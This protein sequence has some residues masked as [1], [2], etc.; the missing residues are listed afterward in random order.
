MSITRR[1]RERYCGS[2]I[3][4]NHMN[5]GSPSTA[6]FADGLRSVVVIP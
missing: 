5:L 1:E 3:R 2:S 4:G 6:R